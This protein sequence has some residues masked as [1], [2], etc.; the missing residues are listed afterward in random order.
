MDSRP[1][2]FIGYVVWWMTGSRREFQ[3]ELIAE[4]L[5]IYRSVDMLGVFPLAVLKKLIIVQMYR[6]IYR[7]CTGEVCFLF[8]FF[9]LLHFTYE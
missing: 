3:K 9:F 8:F 6:L 5:Y 4:D 2:F 1:Y 7:F